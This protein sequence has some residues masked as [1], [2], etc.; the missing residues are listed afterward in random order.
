MRG[1]PIN[2]AAI[3]V[4]E[5]LKFRPAGATTRHLITNVIVDVIDDTHTQATHYICAG[6]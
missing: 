2:V 4:L 3:E 5:A 6:F 1:P